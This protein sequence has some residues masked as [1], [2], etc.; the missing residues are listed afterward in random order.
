MR[1]DSV[2]LEVTED[3]LKDRLLGLAQGVQLRR[4]DSARLVD[5]HQPREAIPP[6]RESVEQTTHSPIWPR[7]TEAHRQIDLRANRTASLEV[8]AMF[9]DVALEAL[10]IPVLWVQRRH[11][12]TPVLSGVEHPGDTKDLEVG[13]KCVGERLQPL[14][15]F[16][17]PRL[18]EA[19]IAM[20]SEPKDGPGLSRRP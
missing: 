1:P 14:A 15:Y 16:H 9:G 12:A 18:R 13:F 19:R 17:L 6:S 4:T 8:T 2:T 3:P 7:G 5:P 20:A 11:C 10:A